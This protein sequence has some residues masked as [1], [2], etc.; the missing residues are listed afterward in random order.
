MSGNK[1]SID[2][3]SD[4]VEEELNKYSK[5]SMDEV[6]EAVKSGAKTVKSEIS[7]IAPVKT[8]KYS[9]SWAIKTVIDN[10]LYISLTVYSKMY[11]L[12]HLLEHGHALRNG[13]RTRAFPHIAPAE[14]KGEEELV[15]NLESKL[16]G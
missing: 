5:T 11:R 7:A 1:V 15:K 4:A 9:K 12:P 3:F 8:G 13:G 16:K 10:E 14:K 6:K 2:N